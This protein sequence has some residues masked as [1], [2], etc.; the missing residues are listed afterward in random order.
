LKVTIEVRYFA[1]CRELAG[2]DRESYQFFDAITVADVR[3][4]IGVRHPGLLPYF[5]VIRLALN[6]EFVADD[7]SVTDGDELA[8][9][10]PV[11]GGVGTDPHFILSHA[12]IEADAAARLL[13]TSDAQG[14]LATF[15]G[16]VRKESHGKKIQYLDY[17]AFEVMAVAKLKGIAEEAFAQWPILEVAVVHRIGRVGVGEVAISIAVSSSRRAAA[18]DGCRHMIERI[19]EDVPIWKKEVAEDGS[20]WWGGAG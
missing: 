1:R 8:L 18:F 16:T 11:S 2:M 12:P 5:N 7:T 14:A 10:P 20:H 4:E 19:K 17:E 9:I 3:T 13:T 15:V 6:Q